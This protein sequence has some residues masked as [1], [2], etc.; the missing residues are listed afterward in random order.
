MLLSFSVVNTTPEISANEATVKMVSTLNNMDDA[1]ELQI[2]TQIYAPNGKKVASETSVMKIGN[3]Q[4]SDITQFLNVKSPVLWSVESPELY[5]AIT[6]V[7]SDDHILDR[8]E[9]TFGIC[10]IRFDVEKGFFLNGLNNGLRKYA[11]FIRSLD[12]T[13]PVIS[14]MERGRDKNP[15]D[16]KVEGIIESCEYMD[17]MAWNYGEQW[18]SLIGEKNPGKSFVSKESYRY[19]LY[20]AF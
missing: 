10:S 11:S 15:P 9:S 8:Y 2:E 14:G 1:K 12:S 5:R 19:Y 16:K 4:S 17:L 13:R 6:F 18:C 7:K 20:K 3:Y